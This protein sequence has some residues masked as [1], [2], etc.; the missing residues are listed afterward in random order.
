MVLGWGGNT[1]K[2]FLHLGNIPLLIHPLRVLDAVD[3]VDEIV[4]VIPESDRE[5]FEKEILSQFPI[6]KISRVIPGGLRRQDSVKNGLCALSDPPDFILV[7]DGAR[8]FLTKQMVTQAIESAIETGASVV[9]LPMGDTVKR[10]GSTG[11]IES[12]LDREE[13]WLAQT[14]QVFRFEWLMKAHEVAEKNHFEATDDAAMVE[15]LGYPVTLVNGSV[16]NMKI[17]RPEDL[18]LGEAILAVERD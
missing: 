2:Q 13:L 10:V 14:P 11:I 6:E 16:T 7:H 9:G 8:P 17:T 5:F 4:L 12:T 18:K 15:R 3:T 1:P